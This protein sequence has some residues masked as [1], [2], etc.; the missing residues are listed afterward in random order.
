MITA[1]VFRIKY[2]HE[3]QTRANYIL[4]YHMFDKFNFLSVDKL[5][6]ISVNNLLILRFL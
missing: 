6:L 5:P 4:K 1:E 3:T 2:L